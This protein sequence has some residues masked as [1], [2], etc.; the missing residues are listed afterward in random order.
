MSLLA[1]A[2][3]IIVTLTGAVVVVTVIIQFISDSAD[4][5]WEYLLAMILGAGILV[6]PVSIVNNQNHIKEVDHLLRIFDLQSIGTY[7]LQN[8]ETDQTFDIN[9]DPGSG[10]IQLEEVKAVEEE[11]EEE[12]ED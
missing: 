12:A 7:R 3:L 5:T 2:L 8:T 4:A 9:V 1:G 10:N 11:A 6:W